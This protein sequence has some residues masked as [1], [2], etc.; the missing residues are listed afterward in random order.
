[1]LAHGTQMI[2]ATQVTI[3]VRRAFKLPVAVDALGQLRRV[4]L[5]LMAARQTMV[6][7]VGF[8]KASQIA[9]VALE[10]PLVD[11]TV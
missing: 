6:P 3:V 9:Q 2:L 7:P 4:G 5:A 11:T 10:A 1:M 8:P